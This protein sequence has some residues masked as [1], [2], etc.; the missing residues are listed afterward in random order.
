[1]KSRAPKFAALIS[2]LLLATGCASSAG[3]APGAA[4]PPSGWSG[5]LATL[6]G[7]PA[8]D[9]FDATLFEWN[10]SKRERPVLAKLYRPANAKNSPLV[11]VS[12]GIGGSREGYSYIGKFLASNGIAS[13]HLQ[14]A[15]S[16]RALWF[17]NPVTLLFRLQGAAQASEAIDRARDVSFALDRVLSDATLVGAFD[18]TRIAMTGHS[19]GANTA[20]LVSGASVEQNEKILQFTDARIKA[21]VIISAPPFY[22]Q[23]DP[24]AILGNIRI[25]TLHITATGDEITIP[26]YRSGVEDRVAVYDAMGTRTQAMKQLAVFKEGSHSMF[27]DRLNTGGVELNPKVKRATRELVLSFL[28]GQFAVKR[29]EV[30]GFAGWA[31]KY[32]ELIAQ[33]KAQ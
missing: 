23:G 15:G 8:D 25:P 26:G 19:Y 16:D 7:M 1:M 33:T 10:D 17:G 13:L 6:V 30:N 9:T 31:K 11:V 32:A 27:T 20:L 21:A 5:A 24:G 4:P 28:Q 22:G 18:A 3:P 14:H 29:E 12:H 2:A